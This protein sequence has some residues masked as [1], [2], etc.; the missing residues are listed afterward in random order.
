MR[1]FYPNF[2]YFYLKI[3]AERAN[4]VNNLSITFCKYFVKRFKDCLA[5]FVFHGACR[6]EG[7]EITQ[8]KIESYNM[9]VAVTVRIT[10]RYVISESSLIY[11]TSKKYRTITTC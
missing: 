2:Q 8:R 6:R 7:L 5:Q 1:V 9:Y 3:N 11:G 10:L 4:T